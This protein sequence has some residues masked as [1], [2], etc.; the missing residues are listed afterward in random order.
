MSTAIAMIGVGSI[1]GCLDL[2]FEGHRHLAQHDF[3]IAVSGAIAALLVLAWRG[4]SATRRG[5]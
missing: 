4:W 1:Y 5:A 3:S 2:I